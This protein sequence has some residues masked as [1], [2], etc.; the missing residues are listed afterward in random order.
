MKTTT[1]SKEGTS[2]LRTL[3][4]PYTPG[5]GWTAPGRTRKDAMRATE[6]GLPGRIWG[7]P[8]PQSPCAH[9]PTASPLHDNPRFLSH[10][11]LPKLGSAWVRAL[12]LASCSARSNFPTFAWKSW[13]SSCYPVKYPY[14]VL[15][16]VLVPHNYPVF[17]PMPLPFQC[18]PLPL[19]VRYHMVGLQSPRTVPRH[20][21]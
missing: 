19:P 1:T 10:E 11:A 16:T 6:R 4:C 18:N 20:L 12:C 21:F 13:G 14:A 17:P 2:P 5:S 3:P 7:G 8:F 15:L 9:R